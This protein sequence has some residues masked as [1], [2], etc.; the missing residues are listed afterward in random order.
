MGEGVEG[1]LHEVEARRVLGRGGSQRRCAR[2]ARLGLGGSRVA[3]KGLPRRPVGNRP[4]GGQERLGLAGRQGVARDRLGEGPLLG[5]AER[6]EV[7]GRGEGK[8]SVIEAEAD[9]G[10]EPAREGEAP[11]DPELLP[12]EE[13][14]DRAGGETVLVR[15][16]RRHARLV[17]GA[18]GLPGGVRFEEPRFGGDAGDGLDEDGDLAPA[19]AG[20]EGEAFEAVEDFVDA[21]G[22]GEDAQRQEGER[23]VGIAALAAEG[24]EGRAHVRDGHEP[25]G[26]HRAS[27]IGRIW[28]RG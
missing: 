1:L 7:E 22:G 25:H 5:L 14:G 3:Q 23:T 20:P 19:L 26:V 9:L 6:A 27:S 17:H 10:C 13:L 16:R 18:G 8:P 21:V 11:P 4:V 2:I 12:A 15:Q 28:K 24:G